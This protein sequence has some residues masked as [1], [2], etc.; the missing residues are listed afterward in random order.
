MSQFDRDQMYPESGKALDANNN[1]V[2]LIDATL[3]AKKIVEQQQPEAEDNTNKVI[4]VQIRPNT[5]ETYSYSRYS[6]F[7]ANVTQ[8]IKAAAGKVYALKCHNLNAVDRYLQL[9]NTAATPNAGAVPLF[10]VL[11]P[12]GTEV[13]IGNDFFG[14]DG[15]P[16]DTGIAFAFSTTET[17]YTAAVAADQVTFVQYK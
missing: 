9:H 10:T 14:P 1:V 2:D 13:V 4:A 15:M 12:A 6:N 17:T 16:F 7:G 3:S 5:A 11:I 8:N